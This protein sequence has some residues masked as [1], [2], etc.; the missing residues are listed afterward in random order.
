MT[1]WPIGSHGHT[2]FDKRLLNILSCHTMA[3]D[4]RESSGQGH[5]RLKKSVL[6]IS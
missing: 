2:R 5:I 6:S 4:Y 1:L 3:I